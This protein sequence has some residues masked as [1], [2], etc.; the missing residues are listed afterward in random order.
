MPKRRRD[1]PETTPVI[2]SGWSTWSAGIKVL[3]DELRRAEGTMIALSPRALEMFAKVIDNVIKDYE[4]EFV[5]KDTPQKNGSIGKINPGYS[6]VPSPIRS[7]G[8]DSPA[9]SPVPQPASPSPAPYSPGIPA[10]TPRL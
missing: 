10:S 1:Q 4:Q 3:H 9:F 7:P 6:P 5:I 8:T 2:P